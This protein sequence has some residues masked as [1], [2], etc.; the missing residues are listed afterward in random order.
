MIL[1]EEGVA[2]EELTRSIHESL[3]PLLFTWPQQ[4]YQ[5]CSGCA[6]GLVIVVGVSWSAG[7]VDAVQGLQV[8]QASR[9]LVGVIVGVFT[10][11][12]TGF[13]VQLDGQCCNKG[14]GSKLEEGIQT[15]PVRREKTLMI[16]EVVSTA[17]SRVLVGIEDILLESLLGLDSAAYRGQLVGD[18][19]VDS[20]VTSWLI[21]AVLR[22]LVDMSHQGLIVL[23]TEGN[24]QVTG[25]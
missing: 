13:T 18:S 16:K 7:F 2:Y 12:C 23:L 1:G 10:T 3:S 22:R 6:V 4:F 17:V 11:A 15:V 20:V 19:G 8:V 9:G 14:V 24:Q 21:S 25:Q 5:G